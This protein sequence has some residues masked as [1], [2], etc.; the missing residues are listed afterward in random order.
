MPGKARHERQPR[1]LNAAK[2][3]ELAL[4]YVAR[5]ATSA[6]KLSAYLARKVR[7]RGWEDEREPDIA[8][9]AEKMVRAGYVDD[10]VYARAKGSGLLR[11]G[12]GARRIDQAL[13][14]AGIGE[15]EREAASGSERARREAA[16][17]MARKR[18]FGPFDRNPPDPIR[19]EKQ[20]AAMLRAGH[21]LDSARA[22]VDATSIAA[23]EEWVGEAGDDEP[24]WG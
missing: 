9:L 13:R 15:E 4:A 22:L 6:G 3:E 1:P 18:G 12:Y 5:F 21:P 16:L 2:L 17:A 19:R 23:A 8:A 20:I 11:R 24:E 10:A 7:E 14:A